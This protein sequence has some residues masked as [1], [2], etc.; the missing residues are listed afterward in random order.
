M[1]KF[2]RTQKYEQ[3]LKNYDF[4]TIQFTPGKLDRSQS[5]SNRK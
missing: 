3:I 4:D 2:L 5:R 1:P